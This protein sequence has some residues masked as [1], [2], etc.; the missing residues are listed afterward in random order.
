MAAKELSQDGELRGLGRASA[1]V[2]EVLE[3]WACE[4]VNTF[5]SVSV[6]CHYGAVAGER[7][8]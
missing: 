1:D 4:Q 5:V 3:I 8:H 2:S 6:R 7:M